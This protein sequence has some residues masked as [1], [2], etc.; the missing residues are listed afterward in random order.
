MYTQLSAPVSKYLDDTIQDDIK[1]YQEVDNRLLT[2]LQEA[3]KTNEKFLK[4]ESAISDIHSVTDNLSVVQADLLTHVEQHKLRDVV[5]KKLD[6]LV[7]V[8]EAASAAIRSR[9]I[10]KVQADVVTKFTNDKKLKES[11]LTQAIAI[12]TAGEE[13]KL[14]K[15]IVG[16]AFKK[17]LSSYREEYVKQ[18]AGS[19]EILIQ[20]DKD[21][22]D[23]LKLPSYSGAEAKN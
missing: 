19:D 10:K 16:E 15:D 21:V 17:S 20:L 11:A 9:M 14:G 7:A 13:G 5:A 23:I 18:P 6:S 2:G 8:E 12:L 22:A 4:L 1:K 3:V